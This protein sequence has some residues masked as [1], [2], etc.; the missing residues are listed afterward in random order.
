[1]FQINDGNNINRKSRKRK[2]HHTDQFMSN[3][4]I[5]RYLFYLNYCL[6]TAHVSCRGDSHVIGSGVSNG[7]RN[8]I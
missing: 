5:C 3:S 8:L 1:M 4:Y 7:V 6:Y 2:R